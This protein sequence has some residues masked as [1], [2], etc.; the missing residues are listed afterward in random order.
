M[1][2]QFAQNEQN[3]NAVERVIHYTELSPEGDL[4]TP[5]D[6]A[7]SW[8]QNGGIQFTNVD[9][10]YRPG[11]PL[12]LKNVSFSIRPREKIG[13]VGRTGAG[14]SSLLQALFR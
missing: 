10:A 12:V 7:E 14:K 11:L 4:Q 8:P 9:L 2:S 5:E 13:I 3:M 6:P 1:V